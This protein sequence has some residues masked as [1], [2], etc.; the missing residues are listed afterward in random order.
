M[1]QTAQ[2]KS[3]I[4]LV[5][6]REQ[7][8]ASAR[9]TCQRPR[10]R[11][12]IAILHEMV[13]E[14]VGVQGLAPAGPLFARFHHAESFVEVEAGIPLAQPVLAYGHVTAGT[15]P[16]GPAL[17]TSCVGRPADVYNAL[18]ALRSFCSNAGLLATGGHWECYLSH[19]PA[20]VDGCDCEVALYLPVS[21]G[22]ARVFEPAT[23]PDRSDPGPSDLL[24]NCP[25]WTPPGDEQRDALVSVP[26][27]R[28]SPE[29][30]PA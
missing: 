9:A 7:H 14:A 23:E 5:G 20:G 30:E 11:R 28:P 10:L 1:S 27:D 26:V 13:M 8:V 21:R 4:R 16:G 12:T 15:L 17:C 24:S 29:L 22:R 18:R 3:A 25:R 2:G 19:L 6:L